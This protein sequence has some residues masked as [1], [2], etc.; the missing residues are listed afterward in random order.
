MSRDDEV[1]MAKMM[2]KAIPDM[3]HPVTDIF[4]VKDR[5][6]ATFLV[7]GTHE[8]GLEGIPATRKKLTIRQTQIPRRPSVP[9]RQRPRVQAVRQARV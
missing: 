9:R 8:G 2:M 6:V 3:R 4:A 1:A 7:E 5:V